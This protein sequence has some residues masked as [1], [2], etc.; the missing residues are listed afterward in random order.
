MRMEARPDASVE[1][2]SQ[3]PAANALT[4]SL[5]GSIPTGLYVTLLARAQS[6]S[7]FSLDVPVCRQIVAPLISLA[8]FTPSDFG[9]RKPWPS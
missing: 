4:T 5:N 8:L 3:R 7:V 1:K 9:T 6:A 2:T